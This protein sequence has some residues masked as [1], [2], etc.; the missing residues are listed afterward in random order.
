MNDRFKPTAIVPRAGGRDRGDM[1]TAPGAHALKEGA[2][3]ARHARRRPRRLHQHAAGV[4]A[5]L[6]GDPPM[7]GFCDWAAYTNKSR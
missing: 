7:V 1:L 3:R 2:Q 6:L 5:S 4:T